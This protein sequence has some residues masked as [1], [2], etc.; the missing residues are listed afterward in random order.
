MRNPDVTV[1]ICTH[2]NAAMLDRALR[3]LTRQKVVGASW[4]LLVVDNGS[5]DR[6]PEL[7]REWEA[8]GAFPAM[9]AIREEQIGLGN[10]RRAAIREARADLIAFIDD[11]CFLNLGWISAAISF[12]KRNPRCGAFGGRVRIR[13]ET[14]PS[15]LG[16]AC[17]WLL[18]RQEL[19]PRPVKLP[20]RGGVPLVGAGIV[21]R[22]EA[23]D[24]SGWVEHAHFMGRT[25]KALTSGDDAE[26]SFRIRAAGWDLWY[27]PTMKLDHVLGAWRSEPR[28]LA[29]LHRAVGRTL[30]H[31][32][33]VAGAYTRTRFSKPFFAILGLALAT[34]NALS[35][36][37][38]LVRGRRLRAQQRWLQAEYHYGCFFGAFEMPAPEP[39]PRPVRAP[40]RVLPLAPRAQLPRRTAHGALLAAAP[41]IVQ[42]P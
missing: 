38:Y 7:L 34:K 23:L 32:W 42:E 30:P 9:R 4:E 26:I 25:G 15:E 11:D 13:W 5:S 10:A 20:S 18:A 33:I 37:N 17:E 12:A 16:E 28:Y 39:R 19:G 24:R 40:E 21:I 36:L 29:R 27:T 14:P 6:T 22:R 8:R 31:I 3:R 41:S 35:A 1:A 2:N